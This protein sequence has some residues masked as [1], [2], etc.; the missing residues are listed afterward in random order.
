[1]A[2]G[3]YT[4]EQVDAAVEALALDGERFAHAQEIVTHAA[5]GLQQ[6]LGEALHAG[7]FFDQ[8]HEAEVTRV[9][10]ARAG[11]TSGSP[12]CARSSPRRPGSGCSS[13]S[14]WG[15]GSGRSCAAGPMHRTT[16]GAG[17]EQG[18]RA[19]PGPF[20]LRAGAR[21][22]DRPHR[23]VPHGQPEGRR[24]APTRSPRT[25]SC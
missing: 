15:S 2:E 13:A 10:D 6:I 5:P 19:V 11:A 22:H 3:R 4:A 23:P 9:A 7:G 21:G 17:H 18:E 8:A 16:K 25:R 24:D 20:G 14:P 12:A 1:M